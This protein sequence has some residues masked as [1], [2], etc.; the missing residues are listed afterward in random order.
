MVNKGTLTGFV[1]V[2]AGEI[3]TEELPK[4]LRSRLPEY[5]VP[6]M[7][8]ARL[9]IDK[10]FQGLGL[11]KKLLR[12]SFKLA[13]EM[14]SRYG[15]VGI[16]VDAKPESLLFYQKMGFIPLQTLSGELGDRPE[17]QPVFLAIKTIEQA[18]LKTK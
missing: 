10:Q 6:I 2:S 9:A 15:C 7:R 18:I 16:V 8:I 1:T 14:K 5:P 17:P 4:E 11:G 3:S 12:A 13:L